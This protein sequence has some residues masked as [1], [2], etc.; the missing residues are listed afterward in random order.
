MAE[1]FSLTS[2]I[3]PALTGLV[4]GGIA[5]ATGW[6]LM[7]ERLGKLETTTEAHRVEIASLKSSERIQDTRLTAI[8][9]RAA[10]HEAKVLERLDSQQKHLN[11]QDKKLDKIDD[12]I[13]TLLRNKA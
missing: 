7:R 9:T 2:L 4:T 12:K 11:E 6:V 5:V 3:G 13:D 1:P 8:E 10:A